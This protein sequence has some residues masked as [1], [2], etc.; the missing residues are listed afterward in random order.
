MVFCVLFRSAQVELDD[1]IHKN[2]L[3]PSEAEIEYK[4]IFGFEVPWK[5]VNKIL[6]S[7]N[8]KDFDFKYSFVKP[9]EKLNESLKAELTCENNNSIEFRD[10]SSGEKVLLTLSLFIIQRSLSKK[11]PKILLLDEIDATLHP[12]MCK[13]FINTLKANLVDFGTRIIFATHN[14][15][16]I[17]FCN[18]AE[19]GIFTIENSKKIQNQT[20]DEA[21]N[22]LSSGV[23]SLSLG[24]SFLEITENENKELFIFTEVNNIQYIEH[25]AELYLNRNQIEKIEFV[26]KIESISGNSQLKTL[27]DFF[28]KL[29]NQKE[30]LFVWDCDCDCIEKYCNLTC[31][32]NVH[33]FIFEKNTSNIIAKKG[34]ENLFPTTVFEGFINETKKSDGIIH[35]TFDERKNEFSK[36]ILNIKILQIFENFTPLF[37][38]IKSLLND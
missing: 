10:L 38:K 25:C 13:N 29:N 19:D 28:T 2:D 36:K 31:S 35:K 14:P 27:F 32:N 30:I 34:I 17:A 22:I 24:S 9:E 5:F 37:D 18:E 6:K 12:S 4:N 26:R 11:F 16:T 33:P 20:K 15:S 21:I 8:S 1:I 23:I 3:K 7:Y